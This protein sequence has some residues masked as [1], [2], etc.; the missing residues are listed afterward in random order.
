ME[1]IRLG[2]VFKISKGKKVE[3]VEE[4]SESL[5]RYIQIDDLRN[6][7]NIKYCENNKKYVIASKNDIIIAW[8]GANAGT[9]SY[10]LEGA[11]GSTLA[12][13]RNIDEN[14]SPEYVG[15]F[16]QSKF[17]YLRA[18][19]TGATIPHIS[20]DA[21]TKIEI[22]LPDSPT[23]QKIVNTLGTTTEL[24]GKRKQQIQA[25]D[26]LTQSIFYD[27]FGDVLSNDK[28]WVIKELGDIAESRLGKMLDKKKQTGEN[29]HPYLANYN[30]Q[31][32]RFNLESLNEMD[33]DEKDRIEFSLKNDD[34]L[35][36]EGGEVGRAAVWKE[37]LENC[38][39][40]KAL[41]RVRCNK[42][43][44]L[45][46]YLA[47]YFFVRAKFN[48]FQDVVG[49]VSTIPHLTGIKLKKLEIPTPS[50]EEQKKFI[51]TLEKI[52]QQ[53]DIL[54]RGLNELET[55][56]NALRQKAFKGELF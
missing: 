32:F 27:M 12:I 21:L 9:I 42:E 47:Y 36:C 2:D 16:L 25:L 26:D 10:G 5:I 30:V 19:C 15:K 24:I 34:L 1:R 41:H 35:V 37:D 50:L 54:V 18:T 55:N 49:G 11:I 23:Q 56:F 17:P 39:F 29:S 53:K 28:N 22:P 4:H 31:W 8:D 3:Q 38:Y 51:K 33:F 7:N 52:N 45:P 48:Q 44:I 14:I 40:Q 6:D 20:R 43:I 46:E 13:L